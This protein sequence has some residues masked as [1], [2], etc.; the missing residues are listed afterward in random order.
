MHKH[1]MTTIAMTAI[2]AARSRGVKDIVLTGNLTTIGFCGKK[3]EEFNNL[4]YGVRFIIPKLAQ[5]ATA[6]GTALAGIDK[7][8]EETV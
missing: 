8:L 5:Y 6:I 4:G 1:I 7:N 3:F 2:F